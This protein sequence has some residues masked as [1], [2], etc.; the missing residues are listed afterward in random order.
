[1]NLQNIN[2]MNA[3]RKLWEQHVMWTRSFIISTLSELPDT[4]FVTTQLLQNPKDLAK[5]FEDFYGKDI[6]EEFERLFTD[7]LLIAATLVNEA[8]SGNAS[9]VEAARKQWYENASDIARFLGSINSYWNELKWK[10]L[11][12]EHLKMTEEEAVYRLNK[13][14]QS[15]IMIYDMIED[16]AL[17]MADYMTEGLKNQ[18]GF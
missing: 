16:G 1:M 9:G 15:D 17:M 7:H 3:L 6:A 18:F 10:S 13:Q 11:L 12:E 4:P 8:K 5:I 2:L 14:Y